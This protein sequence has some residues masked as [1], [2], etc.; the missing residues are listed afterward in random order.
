MD[1]SRWMDKGRW[2]VW[3]WANLIQMMP[4][5]RSQDPGHG[6]WSLNYVCD[7]AAQVGSAKKRHQRT[8]PL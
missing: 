6:L 4:C 2:M 3:M 5:Q 8:A 7:S 1:D